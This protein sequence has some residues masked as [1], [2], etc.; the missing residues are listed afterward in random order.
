MKLVNVIFF[1]SQAT[2]VT[3]AITI[4]A[5]L[6]VL[7]WA[8]RFLLQESTFFTLGTI[9]SLGVILL[10][11]FFV[12]IGHFRGIRNEF[13]EILL[14][15]DQIMFANIPM[16][17]SAVLSWFLCVELPVLDLSVCFAG[18]Y[19]VYIVNIG[20]F[21][22]RGAL[23]ITYSMPVIISPL[24]HIC[25]HHNVLSNTLSRIAGLS[26]SFLFPTLL[27]TLAAEYQIQGFDVANKDELQFNIN[28]IKLTAALALLLCVQSHPMLDDLKVFCSLP[29][30]W[31]S[32]VLSGALVFAF[33]AV[34]AHRQRAK[35]LVE[36]PGQLSPAEKLQLRLASPLVTLFVSLAALL[37]ALLLDLP[38]HLYPSCVAG[39][40]CLA[41]HY[42]RISTE[43]ISR[44]SSWSRIHLLIAAVVGGV[45]VGLVGGAL[46]EKTL[47]NITI[48]FDWLG[49]YHWDMRSF[50]LGCV[51]AGV[52]AA[53]TPLMLSRAKLRRGKGGVLASGDGL[54][55]GLFSLLLF[56]LIAA[57]SLGE[58]MLREQ[59]TS[60]SMTNDV[61]AF[62][63]DCFCFCLCGVANSGLD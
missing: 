45:V 15:L 30:H 11:S 44:S 3:L 1:F 5:V 50:C 58:L 35:E 20:K 37:T 10:F 28:A 60:L 14:F 46:A 21:I 2:L 31:A 6:S 25:L 41:E 52:L 24:L 29:D 4:T 38:M 36:L 40:I 63:I 8:A 59:V 49:G 23:I 22:P 62:S 32:F 18:I 48:S 16:V 7:F 56:S 43:M 39:A 61:K 57:V 55:A 51:I 19:F 13:D 12:T 34:Q 47:W 27:M 33:A 53:L 54:T 9:L 42:Q 17:C 26:I